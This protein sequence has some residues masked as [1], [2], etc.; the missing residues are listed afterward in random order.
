M[1]GRVLKTLSRPNHHSRSPSIFARR[2]WKR[3]DLF[4]ST[5]DYHTLNRNWCTFLG[6]VKPRSCCIRSVHHGLD[7]DLDSTGAQTHTNGRTSKYAPL[8]DPVCTQ[9]CNTMPSIVKQT[10]KVLASERMFWGS[11]SEDFRLRPSSCTL[12]TRIQRLN[13]RI[14]RTLGFF[15]HTSS[16]RARQEKINDDVQAKSKRRTTSIDNKHFQTLYSD[17]SWAYSLKYTLSSSL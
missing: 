7:A 16:S 15:Q 8:E 9:Y 14:L 4:F 17:R 1:L 10:P 5:L 12:Q 2:S 3:L 11:S 6:T 13:A